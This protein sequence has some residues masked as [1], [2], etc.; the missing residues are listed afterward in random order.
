MA[1][2]TEKERERERRREIAPF[3]NL[4]APGIPHRLRE[5]GGWI[6]VTLVKGSIVSTQLALINGL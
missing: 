4:W 3:P 5:G 2:M 6:V 1:Y